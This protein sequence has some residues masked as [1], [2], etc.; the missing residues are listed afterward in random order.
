LGCS[1]VSELR[2]VNR[3]HPGA[4]SSADLTD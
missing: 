3:K 2:S 1:R 4:W